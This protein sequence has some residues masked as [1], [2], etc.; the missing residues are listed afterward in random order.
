MSNQL[1]PI[2]VYKNYLAFKNH[3]TKEKYDYFKY[4]GRS[5]SSTAA[6]NKRKDRYFFE[7]MSRKKTEKEI[8]NFFLANFI[9]SFDSNSVWI[10]EI[11]DSGEKKYLKWEERNNNLF[12]NFKN[13]ADLMFDQYGL[14]EFFSCKK[15]HSPILKEYFAENI[16]IEEM[17]IYD[18][19]FSYI[20]DHDKQLLD[21]VWETVSIKIKKYIPFLNINMLKYKNYLIT[22][23]QQGKD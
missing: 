1:T 2:E 9:E 5:R 20:K 15:G 11:I 18:K 13:N 21:P 10:G 7:R 12:E 16:S 6:F 14:E 19:I 22:K 8:R 17:V 23:L 3:F 4:R